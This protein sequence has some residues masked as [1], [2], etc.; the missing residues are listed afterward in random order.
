[1]CQCGNIYCDLTSNQSEKANLRHDILFNSPEL[2]TKI[3][4]GIEREYIVEKAVRQELKSTHT[5]I[6]LKK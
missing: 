6:E 1:M 5:P 2:R 3:P 4:S